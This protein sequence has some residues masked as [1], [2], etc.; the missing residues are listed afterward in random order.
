[1]PNK[2]AFVRGI[3]GGGVERSLSLP[4]H[5]ASLLTFTAHLEGEGFLRAG[6]G[7]DLTAGRGGGATG[8]ACDLIGTAEPLSFLLSV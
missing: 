1:M 3:L 4:R 6:G 2:G 7:G 8:P 5:R